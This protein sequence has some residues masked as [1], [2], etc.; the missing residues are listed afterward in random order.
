[1]A[2]MSSPTGGPGDAPSPDASAAA[3]DDLAHLLMRISALRRAVAWDGEAPVLPDL[4][5]AAG[6]VRTHQPADPPAVPATQP[7]LDALVAWAVGH[8]A[9]LAP[10][11]RVR[12]TATGARVE[13]TQPIACGTPLVEV[14]AQLM[15]RTSEV[16]RSH[17]RL[18]PWLAGAPLF[19]PGTLMLWL[20]RAR[21][22]DG[23][24][25]PA[26]P[27]VAALPG[28]V[29]GTAL[30]WPRAPG[31]HLVAADLGRR[32][33]AGVLQLY[34]LVHR[35]LRATPTADRPVPL[36]AFTL[37][38]WLWA[39]AI[40]SSRQTDLAG[41]LA[42]VPL[43]DLLDHDDALPVEATKLVD[44][45]L[46][47][48][49]PVDLAPGE[50][51]RMCYGH[52]TPSERWVHG[53]FVPPG[54]PD[55]ARAALPF[56]VP[57]G[58]PLRRDKLVWVL[59]D[60]DRPVEVTVARGELDAAR[61]RARWYALDGAELDH[62]GF[63]SVADA[64]EQPLALTPAGEARAQ[65]LLSAWLDARAGTPLPD[66]AFSREHAFVHA[67]AHARYGSLAPAPDG[68]RLLD[69]DDVATVDAFL[70]G[71]PSAHLGLRAAF[72]DDGLVFTGT[73]GSGTWVGAFAGD[74]LVGVAMHART[75]WLHVEAPLDAAR[76][77]L[78]ALA[79]SGRALAGIAG[80]GE[81]LDV[82]RAALGGLPGAEARHRVISALDLVAWQPAAASPATLVRR[83]T[84]D[85][86]V[87]LARWASVA[88]SPAPVTGTSWVVVV[89][90]AP[91]A[92]AVVGPLV[93]DTVCVTDVV[94]APEQRRRGH[95]RACL[96][97]ALGAAREAGAARAIL[98]YIDTNDAARATYQRLGFIEQGSYA[99][100]GAAIDPA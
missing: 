83:A 87:A 75:G 9:H 40:L 47:L 35:R 92:R 1:M 46:R 66:D 27:Y 85:D 7:A 14:P 52:R 34:C 56:G 21:F 53:G 42:L 58:V 57:P 31:A 11:L 98:T 17:P 38:R 30:D 80:P 69:D 67:A 36:D 33:L 95:A 62:L 13:A 99:T 84:P 88:D 25:D 4:H 74:A 43:W 6:L 19:G 39:G 89:E 76:L 37:D 10:G 61:A 50:A 26:A 23:A 49:A 70:A 20:V 18:A 65:A 77:A 82:A 59:S 68:V 91:V 72:R 78:G 8:G 79:R 90:G 45:G 97:A 41:E 28:R 2:A 86:L 60:P 3:V 100:V 55:G 73:R 48:V 71:S 15:V 29:P 81:Q 32:F 16:A 54:P 22:V 5:V 51:A 93:G 12:A 64:W 94:T 44:G 96:T 63:S 24:D